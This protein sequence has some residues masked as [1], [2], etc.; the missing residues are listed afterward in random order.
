MIPQLR[1]RL[2][3]EAPALTRDA[4]GAE[5]KMWVKKAT[6]WAEVRF[7]GARERGEAD[8]LSITRRVEIVIRHRDD[9]SEE[10]RFRQERRHFIIRG[11][12]DREGDRRFLTCLCEEDPAQNAPSLPAPEEGDD[13]GEEEGG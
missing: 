11:L 6:L 5:M 3:L 12:V 1:E 10:M 2:I 4:G 13:E 8:K 9:I 7:A